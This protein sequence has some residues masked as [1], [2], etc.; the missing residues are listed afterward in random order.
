VAELV[1]K[2]YAAALFEI[3]REK[4]AIDDFET[5]ATVVCQ[6][7]QKESD[8]LKLLEHPKVLMEDKI[9]MMETAFEGKIYDELVG[10]FVLIIKK[11]R[12]IYLVEIL[13]QFLGLV[14]EA[15]G[16][17]KA[18]VTSAIPLTNQ[19]LAQIKANLEK[20]TQ[21]TIDIES[22]VDGSIIGGLVIHVG[23]Q[24]V[25]GSIQGKLNGLKSQLNSLRLA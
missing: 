20:S 13:E 5:Q 4:E 1:T 10:L 12:Q 18:I 15:K 9:K 8:L 11:N 21:K 19:Q 3:A 2:R 24:V 6:I 7:L 25:D 23:D 22:K 17:V 16:Q 14:K